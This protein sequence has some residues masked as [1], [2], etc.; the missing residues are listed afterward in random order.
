MSRSSS[1]ARRG[2]RSC[3][4]IGP[5]QRCSRFLQSTLRSLESCRRAGRLSVVKVWP[6]AHARRALR[7]ILAL[8]RGCERAGENSGVP[9]FLMVSHSQDVE[10][11]LASGPL[12]SSLGSGVDPWTHVQSQLPHPTFP[13][14]R[15]DLARI[16]RKG[17][18]VGFRWTSS[19]GCSCVCIALPTVF[20][21]RALE[22]RFRSRSMVQSRSIPIPVLSQ[23]QGRLSIRPTIM[24]F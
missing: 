24:H 20:G 17:L 13:R 14:V 11:H 18:R 12:W 23:P 10:K 22:L 2:A 5:Q 6:S 1:A 9:C 7:G 15:E 3:D 8:R 4:A 19:A 21:L 16:G